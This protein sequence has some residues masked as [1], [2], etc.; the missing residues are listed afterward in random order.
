MI[1]RIPIKGI[2]R[3]P[4]GQMAADGFC[5]ESLNVQMETGETAPAVR[6]KAVTDASGNP[7]NI[8]GEI[9]FIHK[10]V[11]YENLLYHAGNAVSYTSVIGEPSTGMVFGNLVSGEA[12]ND[13]T[14]VGNT[15]I[16]ATSENMYYSLWKDGA[17]HYLGDK[18]P[19]PDIHFRI[20]NLEAKRVE[21]NA[22]LD[23]NDG[24]FG[25]DV[26][27]FVENGDEIP[28]FHH[29]NE[30]DVVPYGS[31]A[32]KYAFD[33]THDHGFWTRYLDSIWGSIDTLV[34][35]EAREGKAVFPVFVRYAVRLYDGT[36]YAQSIPV[37]LGADILKFVDVK[38]VAFQMTL[39]KEDGSEDALITLAGSF[40]ALANS[41]SVYAH[42]PG[43]AAIF[44]G[45]EDIVTGVDIFVSSQLS[46]VQRNAARFGLKYAGDLLEVEGATQRYYTL[47]DFVLDPYYMSEHQE[48]LLLYH[49]TTYLAKSFETDEFNTLSSERILDDINFTSDY[50]LAQRALAE[51]TQSMHHTIG[52]RLF[53][54]NKRLLLAGAEQ[55]LSNGYPFIHSAQWSNDQYPA[56]T[57]RIVYYLRGENGSNT[58]ICRDEDQH[59]LITPRREKVVKDS[60][61]EY[62]ELPCAWL[63]YPDSRCYRID[64]Y[65]TSAGAIGF[66]SFQTK[67]FDQADVAYVF[68]GFGQRFTRPFP[69]ERRELPTDENTRYSMPSSLVASKVNNPFVFP[70]EDKVTFT[71]GEI[72]NMA[73]ATR[74]LSEGQFGQF[75]LYVF[76][77]E[78][79]FALS[80]DAQGKFL[81][82]HPVSRDILVSRYALA[83][84]EQGVFFA[85]KRG[86]L[87]LQG[88][89]VTKVSSAMEG[90]AVALDD[91][92]LLPFPVERAFPLDRF[93]DGCF[94]AYDYANTR[95]LVF[96]EM[97]RTAYVYKF[98]TQTWHRLRAGDAYP[99]RAL[100]SYPEAQV[101]FGSGRWQS[102]LDFSVLE[103]SEGA[104]ALPG[105]VYSRDLDFDAMDVYKSVSRF[106]VRGRFA[107]Q[108][109]KWQLQ[110]SNDGMNYTTIHSLR[111]PSWKWYRFVLVTNL[112]P[113]ERI[114]Y[115]ELDCEPRFTNKIR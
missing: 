77:D 4:S 37:L 96:N 51:T 75:P 76:T 87:L 20:G 29:E 109:V 92:S 114:S 35:A 86:L 57:Y 6:P 19:I 10:G 78:G 69:A 27:K 17:Y 44:E 54:Y 74:A 56:E 98:D 2:S 107:D 106:K 47:E 21:P 103:E 112:A 70:V 84:I 36:Y 59:S 15:V 115:V 93:L 66:R 53:T 94:I 5:A 41:Y 73:V 13:I 89:Q 45:W 40:V 105:L 97:L 11:G 14:A 113:G 49:Q 8:D 24:E 101:V 62:K 38:A 3:D 81:T 79:V 67:V 110:G 7:V 50:V 95:I 100:N 32:K 72:L 111:G 82:N 85:A 52:D 88:S 39:P 91:E 68:L 16:I 83:G 108:H 9:L 31:L 43:Q 63:A 80:V 65:A 61:V 48:E 1:K 64:I 55:V 60:S 23:Y 99:V 26:A 90:K 12:V 58:I 71:A 46:P 25:D 22:V 30:G 34:N 18:V 28:V 33:E 102:L 42:A 104:E